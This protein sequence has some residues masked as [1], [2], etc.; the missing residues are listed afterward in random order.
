MA[1]ARNTL[2]PRKLAVIASPEAI[3]DFAEF[4]AVCSYFIF[5]C[6]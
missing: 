4:T 3:E 5:I 6:F 1:F 2:F